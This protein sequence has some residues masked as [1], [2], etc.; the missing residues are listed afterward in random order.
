M[1]Y[2]HFPSLGVYFSPHLVEVIRRSLDI[3]LTSEKYKIILWKKKEFKD[4][5]DLP[6]LFR[7]YF[8]TIKDNSC[9]S[10]MYHLLL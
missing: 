6:V 1:L 10:T 5:K 7:L 2:I 3:R 9:I 8:V 4:L